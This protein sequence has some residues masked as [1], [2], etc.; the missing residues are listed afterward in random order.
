M[1]LCAAQ[2]YLVRVNSW[3]LITEQRKLT[4]KT[5]EQQNHMT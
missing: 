2:K 5:T 4:N 3:F 1:K